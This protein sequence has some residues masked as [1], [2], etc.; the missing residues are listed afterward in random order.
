MI[1]GEAGRYRPAT[2]ACD[3][4]HALHPMHFTPAFLVSRIA[5]LCVLREQ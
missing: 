1:D 4:K 3:Q 2:P 5:D